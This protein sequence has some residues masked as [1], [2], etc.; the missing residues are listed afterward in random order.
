VKYEAGLVSCI[1]PVY[2]GGRYV[3]AAMDSI[4][5]QTYR[6]LELIVADD[7]STDETPQMVTRYGSRA[8]YLRQPNA[9]P[10][11]A[12]NL[13]LTAARGEFVAFLDADDL[14]HQEKLARQ[15][16]CFRTDPSL[17]YCVAHVQN[18]WEPD[19]Q[20]EAMRFRG[21][22][23]SRPLPGYTTATLVARRALFDQIGP[24]DAGLRHSDAADWLLRARR[25]GAKELL[26]ADTL[27]FRRMHR[28][29]R[30]RLRA[31]GSR[32]EF[33]TLLKTNLDRRRQAQDGLFPGSATGGND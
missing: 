2:N 4:L 7:G 31:E 25:S 30:S 10:A 3:A 9:G 32:D 24:F 13:G 22:R 21:H 14:W 15:I 26:L 23:R 17:D 8:Q 29:N 11:A 28:S 33:L 6:R 27:V 1:V 18:F 12:R 19:L 16:A 5:G 20:E